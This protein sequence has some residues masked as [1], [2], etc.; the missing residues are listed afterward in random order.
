MSHDVPP[1]EEK[2]R[3]RRDESIEDLQTYLLPPNAELVSDELCSFLTSL[4][5]GA[6]EPGKRADALLLQPARRD[7]RLLYPAGGEA[8]Q[9]YAGLLNRV[10]AHLLPR[11][12]DGLA[13]T[14]EPVVVR[15]RVAQRELLQ[16]ADCM[17]C[18]HARGHSR[19]QHGGEELSPRQ[20][21]RCRRARG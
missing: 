20:L 21:A 1:G 18:G 8:V 19:G 13:G 6:P 15:Q 11:L 7:E 14:Q 4:L 3:P 17:R 2:G 9:L 10:G 5:L 12:G 16:P